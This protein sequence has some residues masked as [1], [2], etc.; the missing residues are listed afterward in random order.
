MGCRD[1]IR[2]RHTLIGLSGRDTAEVRA[3]IKG[4]LA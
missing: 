3:E 4:L 1:D 2:F